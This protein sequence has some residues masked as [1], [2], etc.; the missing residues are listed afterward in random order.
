MELANVYRNPR[1]RGFLPNLAR[2][3]FKPV[4]SVWGKSEKKALGGE[5]GFHTDSVL[6]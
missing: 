4:H 3:V 6:V 1:F 5:V 2:R